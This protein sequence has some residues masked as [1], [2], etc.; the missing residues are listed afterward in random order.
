MNIID[1]DLTAA[2]YLFSVK[3]L[4]LK[5]WLDNILNLDVEIYCLFPGDLQTE[6]EKEY[7]KN[8][9]EIFVC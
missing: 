8:S 5:L 2:L 1:K 9:T 3:S 6:K 4:I 7:L